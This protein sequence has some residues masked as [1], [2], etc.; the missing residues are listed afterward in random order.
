MPSVSMNQ[1]GTAVPNPT[2]T[3][4]AGQLAAEARSCPQ[5]AR[6]AANQPNAGKLIISANCAPFRLRP[7]ATMSSSTPSTNPPVRASCRGPRDKLA[8][9]WNQK[10]LAVRLTAVPTAAAS[11]SP[12]PTSND[13]PNA[14]QLNQG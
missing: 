11:S 10:R 9:E 2:T 6:P 12:I 7:L 8:R 5:P 3:A 1:R 14:P 4:T 13:D